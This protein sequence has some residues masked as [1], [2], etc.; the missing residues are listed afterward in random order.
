MMKSEFENL[1]DRKV[2]DEQYIDI[3]MVYMY[4]PGIENKE[5]IAQIYKIGGDPLINDMIGRAFKIKDIEEKMQADRMAL[6]V[7]KYK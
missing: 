5:Q 6:E 2:T 1:I 3:E 7:L 4:Y